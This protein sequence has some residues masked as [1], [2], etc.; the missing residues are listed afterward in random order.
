M[1]RSKRWIWFPCIGFYFAGRNK[2][3]AVGIISHATSQLQFILY[4]V[5]KI[6]DTMV[7][8]ML[9]QTGVQRKKIFVIQN[10]NVL[11]RDSLIVLYSDVIAH[12]YLGKLET[13]PLIR[14]TSPA[15][16]NNPR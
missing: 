2:N 7:F 12:T 10:R 14:V 1:M 9:N 11:N 16:G 3:V 15:G 6:T 5:S 13:A 8:F 4:P